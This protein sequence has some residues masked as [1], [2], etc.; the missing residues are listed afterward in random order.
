LDEQH[1]TLN[2]V[3][4]Q[5]KFILV[6]VSAQFKFTS[7]IES[8]KYKFMSNETLQPKFT[9]PDMLESCNEMFAFG[10]KPKR[11]ELT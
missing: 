6:M 1:F 10:L 11:D 2:L 4:I 5:R 8:V 7:V 3:T 9:Y